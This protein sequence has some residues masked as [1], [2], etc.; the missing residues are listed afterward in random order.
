[1]FIFINQISYVY[2][3]GKV[4]PVVYAVAARVACINVGRCRGFI[5]KPKWYDLFVFLFHKTKNLTN[6]MDLLKLI[7]ALVVIEPLP[8]WPNGIKII[9]I[10]NF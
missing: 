5:T 3:P 8:Y 6:R 2:P 7:L 10:T 9:E 4:S 1:M